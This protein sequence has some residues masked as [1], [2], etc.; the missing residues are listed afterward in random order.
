MPKDPPR[1]KETKLKQRP[2]SVE[3][4][5][6]QAMLAVDDETLAEL[7]EVIRARLSREEVEDET[8][9]LF[10]QFLRRLEDL[11]DPN[12]V[13]DD[14]FFDDV[15]ASLSQLAIDE[16]GGDARAR[17]LRQAIYDRL[18]FALRLQS[19]DAAALVLVAKV[20]SDSGWTV[21]EAL[22]SQ[23][24][25]SLEA[26]GIAEFDEADLET[27][28]AEIAEAAEGDAFAAYEALNSVLS[29]FPSD[30]AAQMLGALAL[31]RAPVML[32]TLAGFVM[33]RD[34]ALARAAIQ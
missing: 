16:N 21:P 5:A 1:P 8:L 22:K 31:Q 26:T 7:R 14:D 15:V 4:L 32:Q 10:A 33:H 25:D 2:G 13:G 19:L 27:T 11:V 18:T 28:L 12:A 23:L 34:P 6:L 29:A 9:A 24:V 20:L 30:S 3:A 17:G